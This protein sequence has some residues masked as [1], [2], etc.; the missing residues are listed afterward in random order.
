VILEFLLVLLGIFLLPVAIYCAVLAGINRR[1]HPLMVSGRWD[2]VGL[3]FAASGFL[4]LVAPV[5]LSGLYY[6]AV[7]ELPLVRQPG[8]AARLLTELV[9]QQGAVWWGYYAAVLLGILVL[10]WRRRRVTIIYNIEPGILE[11]HLEQVLGRLGLCWWRQ[12]RNYY[13]GTRQWEG[14]AGEKHPLTAG[15][16]VSTAS[17]P[18]LPPNTAP[19]SSARLLLT[20][21][22]FALCY[23]VTL[24][25]SKW[26]G[27]WQA[28]VEAEL[29]REL[30]QVETRNNPVSGWLLG[31]AL[32]LFLL[33]VLSSGLALG[34]HRWR[35]A[36]HLLPSSAQRQPYTGCAVPPVVRL[37]IQ[38]EI[39]QDMS[40]PERTG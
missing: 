22:P 28:S 34:L 17:P 39:V 29:E 33:I 7:R 40:F 25:W 2:L 4:L 20:V 16:A 5:L 10:F 12:G 26:A 30:A 18:V 32:T 35:F 37:E 36:A 24:H 8:T 3:L 14:T 23:N 9:R 19:A 21:E 27:S 13:L 31:L 1:Q 6:R 15:S 11:N 38:R